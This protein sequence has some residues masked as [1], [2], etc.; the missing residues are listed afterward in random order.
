M[1]KLRAI[2]IIS[3]IAGTMG[4]ILVHNKVVID[5]RSQVKETAKSVAVTVQ[6]VAFRNLSENLS[7]IGT[8][9]PHRELKLVSEVQG[10]VVRVGVEEGDVVRPGQLIAQVDN[11]LIGLE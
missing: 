9:A 10:K 7:T 3:V 5:Q 1:K 11:E 2:L 4:F 6:P 8:F